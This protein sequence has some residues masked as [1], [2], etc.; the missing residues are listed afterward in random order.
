MGKYLLKD[1]PRTGTGDLLISVQAVEPIL[2]PGISFEDNLI[3]EKYFD[4]I[5]QNIDN[6]EY[7]KN[8]EQ[9]VNKKIYSI[10]NLNSDESSYIDIFTV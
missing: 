4:E 6:N 3:F 8:I 1:S 7:V 2:I 5:T 9:Q 10:F